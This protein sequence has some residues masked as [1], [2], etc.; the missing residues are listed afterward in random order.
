MCARH[1]YTNWKKKYGGAVFKDLFWGAD[2]AYYIARFERQMEELKKI[3]VATYDDLK[4]SQYCLWSRAFFTEYSSSDAIENNLGEPFNAA[5]RIARTKPVV[6]MLEDIR[7]K[8]YKTSEQSQKRAE[9]DKC[10]ANYTY[11]SV[12]KL[13]EHIELAKNCS[14]LSCGLGDYEVRY[15][16]DKFLVKMRGDIF[17][18]C[19]MYKIGG[20]PCCHIVSAMRLE[21]NAD[22]DLK[23]FIS[24][25]FTIEKLEICYA[26][27]LKPING[28]NMWKVITNVRINP[29][30]F[31]KPPVR[32]PA[33]HN[34]M[35]CK[36]HPFSKSPKNRPG[37]PHKEVIP[38]VSAGL[39]IHAPEGTL[40][41]KW[42]AS[43]SQPEHD[44]PSLSSGLPKRGPGRPR[45]KLSEG[46]YIISF[47]SII[48][49]FWF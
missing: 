15:F 48:G 46:V 8:D 12:A 41:R 20:I 49:N 33:R 29:P 40:G 10:R 9:A 2:D 11:K 23:T 24:N 38:H 22:Q 14:P 16:N 35:Y 44:V 37:R 42:F 28:M 18:S 6:E 32:P 21:K 26:H 34:K 4:I 13:E 5:I 27:P 30:P 43:A 1:V 17:C 19:R 7:R 3:S 39:F 45:K 25:W 31:K 47:C 36:K